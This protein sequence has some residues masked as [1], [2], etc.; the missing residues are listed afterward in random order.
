MELKQIILPICSDDERQRFLKIRARRAILARVEDRDWQNPGHDGRLAIVG[1][2][3]VF[4]ARFPLDELALGGGVKLVEAG[5]ELFE[6]ALAEFGWSIAR[7]VG[8]ANDGKLLSLW[9]LRMNA[10]T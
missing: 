4:Q 7:A 1:E 6:L 5:G 3:P 10:S 2:F 8:R 9:S